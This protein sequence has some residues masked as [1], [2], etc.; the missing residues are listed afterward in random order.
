MSTQPNTAVTAPVTGPVDFKS[1]RTSKAGNI[2]TPKCRISFPVLF[3]PKAQGKDGEG[4]KKYSV[5]VLIPPDCNLQLLKD[6][7][8]RAAKEKW[9]EKMP[10]NLKSPFLD[11]GKY[12]YEGYE[13]GWTLIRSSSI[14]K[15]G[16]VDAKGQNIGDDSTQVYAGRWAC[17]SLRAFAYDNSGN[18]GVSFGL[19][20]IQLLDH[21]TPIAGGRPQAEDEF[22][23]VPEVG[24]AT[25]TKTASDLF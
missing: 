4:K 21:D 5:A 23:P 2:I 17:V 20:N 3:E 8:T 9:G 16:V 13:N 1:C 7:A 25:A 10:A 15:P 14:Q 6:D 18:R 24:G 12:E 22:A 11:A 19:Q